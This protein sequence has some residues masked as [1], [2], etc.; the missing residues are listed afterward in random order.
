MDKRL[1]KEVFAPFLP[2]NACEDLTCDQTIVVWNN[3]LSKLNF[4]MPLLQTRLQKFAI[5]YVAKV[6][7]NHAQTSI[8]PCL[9]LV[10]SLEVGTTVKENTVLGLYELF[11]NTVYTSSNWEPFESLN[12]TSERLVEMLGLTFRYGF[13][14]SSSSESNLLAQ[15]EMNLCGLPLYNMART[16]N[17]A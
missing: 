4:F 13:A 11:T 10:L 12:W 8:K 17:A 2:G 3:V 15:F 1:G 7:M 14:V 6:K 9:K 5:R 16:N